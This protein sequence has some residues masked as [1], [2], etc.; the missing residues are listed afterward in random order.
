MTGSFLIPI[1]GIMEA[2]EGSALST[3]DDVRR[4][5]LNPTMPVGLDWPRPRLRLRVFEVGN[6][7]ARWWRQL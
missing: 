3:R 4:E 5:C 1:G 7:T 6:G 2:V